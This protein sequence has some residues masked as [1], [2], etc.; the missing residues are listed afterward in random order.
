[1]TNKDSNYQLSIVIPVYNEQ[2]NLKK[3]YNA[4]I[5]QINQINMERYQIVFVNDGSSDD[6]LRILRDLHAYDSSVHVIAFSR[7]FWYEYALEAGLHTACGEWVMIMDSDFQ[8]PPYLISELYKARAGY[9]VVLAKRKSRK[10]GRLKDQ[11]AWFFYR[12]INILSD[13]T[14]PED[15]GYCR[16]FSYKVLCSINQC[17]EYN[18]FLKWLFSYV[19]FN[20]QY[21]LYDRPIR[22]MGQTSFTLYKLFKLA[23]Q[24][25]FSLSTYPLKIAT[26]IGFI[27]ALLGF[28]IAIIQIVLKIFYTDYIY[29]ISTTIVLISILW[30]IQLISLWMIGEYIAR[31]YSEVK[32]RPSYVVSEYLK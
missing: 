6:S 15:V 32:W 29:G 9:D 1:M 17:G 16:M 14:I 7:N 25:I 20:V 8:D 27:F 31:I 30:W 10:D 3:L 28:W 23:F 2:D 4:I 19:W 13:V 12:F 18:R 24:A 11:T 5:E 22:H 26:I 21:V